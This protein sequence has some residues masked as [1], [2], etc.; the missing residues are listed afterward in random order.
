[1]ATCTLAKPEGCPWCLKTQLAKIY[2][3]WMLDVWI[4]YLR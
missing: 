2:E 1:M 3:V 4:Q